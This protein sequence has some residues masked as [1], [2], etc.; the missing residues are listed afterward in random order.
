MTEIINGQF[1][2]TDVTSNAM[3]GTELMAL[4][5]IEHIPS[6]LLKNY[7]I[8]HSRVRG[9]IGD[10]AILVLHDLPGDPE[11]EHLKSGGYNKFKKLVFVSNWQMQQ[12]IAYYGIPWHKCCVIQ[13]AIEPIQDVS[14]EK[15]LEKIRIIY[16]TTPHRGLDILVNS[17][18]KLANYDPNIILD[19]YSSY[20]IYGWEER[21]Q[22]FA[23]LF[24]LCKDHPQ[25]NYHGTVSNDKVR[26]A[27]KHAHIFA[28]PSKWPETSCISLIEA[29]SAGLL[30]VH[31]NLACL[32][33]TSSNWTNMYQFQQTDRDHANVF[34]YELDKA[35]TMV[36][37]NATINRQYNQKQY[38]DMF[39][40]WNLRSLQWQAF[41]IEQQ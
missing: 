21:D 39:Y 26:E 3:G 37:N 32:P 15:P 28:Y 2:R 11:F 41:L 17:F 25:I 38:T 5:M 27:L 29:M 14:F 23:E 35:I 8:I 20:K 7:H 4:K 19:V 9:E 24:N 40:N 22:Q 36:R 12:F 34:I 1:V 13:N 31:S 16:H 10:N 18:I 33:E 30:C 6:E